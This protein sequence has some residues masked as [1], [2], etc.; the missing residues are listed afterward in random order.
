VK[1]IMIELKAKCSKE[2]ELLKE[3]MDDS[4]RRGKLRLKKA[5][6]LLVRLK[7]HLKKVKDDEKWLSEC[8]ESVEK[9]VKDLR[10]V[11]GES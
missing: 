5:N 1:K 3:T 6:K 7:G 9:S 4:D 8:I 11:M 2:F 10:S